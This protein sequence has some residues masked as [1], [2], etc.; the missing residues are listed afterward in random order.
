VKSPAGEESDRERKEGSVSLEG[1]V[2]QS[3]IPKQVAQKLVEICDQ[4]LAEN[5]KRAPTAAELAELAQVMVSEIMSGAYIVLQMD[6]PETGAATAEAWL[7]HTLSIGAAAV[8]ARGS[9]ALI[10]IDVTIRNVPNKMP[11]K[12]AVD[13]VPQIKRETPPPPACTCEKEADGRCGPCAGRLGLRF[14]KFFGILHQLLGFQQEKTD[15]VACKACDRDMFDVALAPKV[16]ELFA[17]KTG[18]SS[19]EKL[20]MAQEIMATIFQ[21][22]SMYGVQD[23]PLTMAAWKK[24]VDEAGIQIPVPS[25]E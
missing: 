16:P 2:S 24:A 9:D 19:E 25:A 14:E 11:N 3:N 6:S 22:S 18:D 17:I 1:L 10:K 12:P 23:L 13:P 15:E 7:K 4:V 5:L 20:K 21:M 8:R